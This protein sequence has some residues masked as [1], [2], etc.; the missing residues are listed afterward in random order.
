M[1]EKLGCDQQVG[2]WVS[3]NI[4]IRPARLDR[5]GQVFEGHEHEFDHTTI[6]FKGS[7]HIHATSAE[8]PDK[9]GTFTAPSHVLIKKN[10]VHTITALEDNTEFWCVY[11]HTTP[12]GEISQ[13][14]DGW[15]PAYASRLR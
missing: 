10:W 15:A 4:Y 12:Q 3:G 9:E 1:T 14:Y 8:G 5:K 13:V 6:V 7:V 11:S 2:E